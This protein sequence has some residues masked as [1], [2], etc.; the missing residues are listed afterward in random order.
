VSG[1]AR[2]VQISV[3]PGG[4][5]K[6]AVPTARVTTSGLAGDAQRDLEHHGGPER[7]LCLFS[8]ERINAL[9]TEGHPITPGSIGENLT[10]EGLAWDRV[11]PGACLRL[12]AEVVAQVTRYTA[13]CLNISASFR[14]RDF[15]RVSQKR[16]P[17]NSR[18]YARVIRE[19]SLTSGD[20]VELLTEDQALALIGRR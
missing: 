4:V 17:G 1:G 14:D 10:I 8:S 7:A 12:G 6:R 9:R 15:S 5:P 18:V 13:P 2:I 19:G 3:S 16:H 11:T 20:P